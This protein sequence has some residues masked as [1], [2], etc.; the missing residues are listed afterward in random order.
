MNPFWWVQ[1][2]TGILLI[3]LAFWIPAGSDRVY[4]LQQRTFLILFWVGFFAL[5]KGI[6]QIFTAFGLRH[7]GKVAA[8]GLALIA[9]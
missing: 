5:F 6:S 7:A 2:T 4:A 3:L 9:A 1:L 8:A